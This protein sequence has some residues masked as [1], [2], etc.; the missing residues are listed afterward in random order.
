MKTRAFILKH[1]KV[2]T[3]ILIALSLPA[4]YAFVY[5]TGGIKYVF[6]H[7]MYIP[8]VLAGVVLG[9]P[10]GFLTALIG[11]ILLGPLMPIDVSTHESQDLVNWLYRLLIFVSVGLLTDYFTG[12]FKRTLAAN[13]NLAAMNQETHVPNV[14]FLGMLPDDHH[15]YS[16]MSIIISDKNKINDVFGYDIFNKVINLTYMHLIS[17]LPTGSYVIQSDSHVLWVIMP[18]TETKADTDKVV[19]TLNVPIVIDDVNIFVEFYIGAGKTCTLSEC[20]K[21]ESFREADRYARFAEKNNLPY[22]IYDESKVIKQYQFNLLGEFKNALASDQTYLTYHPVIDLKTMSIYKFEALLR[23]SHPERGLIMPGEFIP[24]IENTQLVH[25]LVDWVVNKGL[26]KLHEF[27]EKKIETRIAFNVSA[28]NFN[29][30]TLYEKI[31]GFLKEKKI[32]PN[33]VSLEIT[34]TV[35][36]ENPDISREVIKKFKQ[37]GITIAID[38]FGKGYSSFAYLSQFD[39]DY[40]KI[41][42]YFIS[43]I[44]DESIFPIVKATVDLAHQLNFKVIAEGVET[45]EA[46]DIVRGLHCDYAQGFY[47][48]KP[49]HQDEVIDYYL[50]NK[51]H[52]QGEDVDE[53]SR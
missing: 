14:N 18:F 21:L 3:G 50:K 39:I 38:D 44:K 9:S 12:R 1:Y 23:W 27:S 45:L 28:N 41:D 36:M 52:V 5:F 10:Y 11:A 42:R 6:S 49:V 26:V 8:I 2:I 15:L 31:M 48:G 19:D 34:E 32:K 25:P 47:F 30:L 43:R 17:Q 53:S 24:L 40:L 46:L 16:T 29:D 7:T 35:L 20:K 4:I 37:A 51:D 13:R 33:Q 22:A